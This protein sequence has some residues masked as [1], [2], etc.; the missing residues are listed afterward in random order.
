MTLRGLFAVS[1]RFLRGFVRDLSRY[2]PA[3]GSG[4]Q[5]SCGV[6]QA[7]GLRAWSSCVMQAVR[8]MVMV[9]GAHVPEFARVSTALDPRATKP[10]TTLT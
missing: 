1:L 6:Y 10:P 9:A 2:I 8:V 4:L 3:I 7:V 5:G